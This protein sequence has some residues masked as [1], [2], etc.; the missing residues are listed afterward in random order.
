MLLRYTAIPP[1]LSYALDSLPLAHKLVT[2]EEQFPA[3]M[4]MPN[5]RRLLEP[6]PA[7]TKMGA[8]TLNRYP[9]GMVLDESTCF[10]DPGDIGLVSAD[11]VGDPTSRYPRLIWVG[12]KLSRIIGVIPENRLL[13]FTRLSGR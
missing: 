8:F 6:A 4:E 13:M 1:M 2:E 11:T 7:H 5:C 12:L 3:T 10:L 9:T